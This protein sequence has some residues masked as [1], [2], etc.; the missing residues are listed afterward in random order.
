[1][2]EITWLDDRINGAPFV[3]VCLGRLYLL[4]MHFT[5]LPDRYK[6]RLSIRINGFQ[7]PDAGY[8]FSGLQWIGKNKI[9][10]GQSREIF[11]KVNVLN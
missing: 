4:E 6:L 1:M 2:G 3:E 9:K 8:V 10:C 5:G 11:I 7:M